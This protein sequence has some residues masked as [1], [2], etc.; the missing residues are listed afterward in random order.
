MRRRRG[1]VT[2]EFTLVG[3]PLMFALIS[4]VE[5]SRGMWIYHTETYAV[6]Q[7]V[8]YVVV[9]GEECSQNGNT[10]TATV[11]DI[12][13]TIASS[14]VGLVPSLWNVT[15]VSASGN[16]NTICNP[17]NTCFGNST[18]WPPS[19][20]NALGANV[21]ISATYPFTS[22]LSMFF[23]GSEPVSFGTFNLP[24]YSKQTIQF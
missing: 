2:V 24:A 21:A 3:I 11:G 19:P 20:D 18:V 7:A 6:S 10:C 12:A 5:M 16:H 22:A 9:H 8:R 14:G 13:S 23:P 4:T 17:L 1:S 15:L